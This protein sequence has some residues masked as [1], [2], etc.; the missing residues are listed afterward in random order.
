[1]LRK[2]HSRSDSKKGQWVNF[3]FVIVIVLALAITM[4]VLT[5]FQSGINDMIQTN[6]GMSNESKVM[7]QAQSDSTGNV[8]DAGIIMV[9]VFMWLLCLGLAYNSGSSPL[10]FVVA[11]FIIFALGFSGMILS[12]SWEAVS[13]ASGFESA[14]ADMPMT[15]YILSHYLV[16]I[17]IVGFTTLMVAFTQRGGF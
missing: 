8:F 3:A 13:E 1:M 5:Q 6:E 14:L 15:N 17:L 10:L 12:N 7:M 16:Y 11:L 4:L 9:L 2:N